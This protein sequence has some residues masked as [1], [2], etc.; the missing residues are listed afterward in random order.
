MRLALTDKTILALQFAASGQQIVRDAELPGFFLMVGK[1]TKT[2]MVQGDLRQNGKRQ[3][4]R[5]KV[6]EVGEVRTREARAKA[7]ALLGLI[8]KGVDPRPKEAGEGEAPN[9]GT[10]WPEGS[11]DI[12]LTLRA[13][14]TRYRDA[15]LKRKGR[16]EGTIENCRDHVE[17]LMAD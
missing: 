15:H 13:A 9:L 14:W 11:P 7:K 10:N 8:G 6:G 4:L 5:L 2:F 16:S 1:R 12:D 17:R 3:S